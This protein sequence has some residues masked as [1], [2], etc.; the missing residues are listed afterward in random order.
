MMCQDGYFDDKEIIFDALIYR[1]ATNQVN[2]RRREAD[3]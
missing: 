1:E 2:W 3:G